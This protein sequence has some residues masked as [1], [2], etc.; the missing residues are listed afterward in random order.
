[1]QQSIPVEERQSFD[2]I[3]RYVEGALR[4]LELEQLLEAGQTCK[5]AISILDSYQKDMLF[6]EVRIKCERYLSM[7]R[8]D[9]LKDL[10]RKMLRKLT[11]R[12]VA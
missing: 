5:Q 8:I 4:Q 11:V 3:S 12:G 10:F 9:R 1:M 6:A 2:F 7:R